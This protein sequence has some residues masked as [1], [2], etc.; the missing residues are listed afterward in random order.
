LECGEIPTV[1]ANKKPLLNQ[2]FNKGGAHAAKPLK[3]NA[4]LVLAMPARLCDKCSS[5]TERLM[6]QISKTSAIARIHNSGLTLAQ[7]IN[8]TDNDLL[9]FPLIGRRTL[10][11][12]RNFEV[13]E[14]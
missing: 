2:A 8:M 4:F 14:T 9:R 13:L 7:A 10:R 6:T 3:L 11:F 12:I 1:D 5:A